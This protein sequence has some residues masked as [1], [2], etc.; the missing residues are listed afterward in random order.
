MPQWD[1]LFFDCSNASS[2]K[3]NGGRIDVQYS[4]VV[5]IADVHWKRVLIEEE[6][7]G[8]GVFNSYRLTYRAVRFVALR[9]MAHRPRIFY[10]SDV[11]AL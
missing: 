7:V 3:A 9:Y 1:P 11:P 5:D 4:E 2:R 10:S 6:I 8:E